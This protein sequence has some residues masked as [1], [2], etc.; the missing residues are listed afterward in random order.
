[1]S[2][3]ESFVTLATNDNYA[4]GALVLAA[5]LRNVQTTKK[6][7]ILITKTVSESIRNVLH[8]S[9]DFV[10]VV[11]LLESTDTSLLE[12]LKRP[13]LGVTLTKLHCWTLTQFNKC[14]F[15]DADTLVVK[16]ID[17]LFEREELSAV[18]DIGWPDCFNSGLFVFRPSLETFNQL[19]QLAA[20]EGSFDGGDQGLLN[21][22]FSD[23]ATK[24][25][26]RHLSFIYNMSIVSTYSYVPAFKRFGHQVKV[27][28]FL[29]SIKPWYCSFNASTGQLNTFCG[30]TYAQEFIKNWWS[31]YVA[32]VHPTI[33]ALN[34]VG[35]M[36]NMAIA[37]P[38]GSSICCTSQQPSTGDRFNAWQQG[39]IDYL[40]A[41]SFDNIQK[42]LDA[43][44]DNL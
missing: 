30:N 38:P 42:K 3:S 27:I 22:Y 39:Q 8:Q 23:W 37:P 32:K 36:S 12:A 33:E 34:L 29:G 7:T 24:D 28:H 1:M 43:V 9:F 10:K 20:K 18:A 21:T 5:S 15:M 13:E 14:V 25:I 11:D 44:I 19:T 6:I 31:I 16:N 26:S 17:E 35:P 4:L 41:D 2:S 40:G